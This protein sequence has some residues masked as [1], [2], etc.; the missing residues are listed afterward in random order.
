[1]NLSQPQPQAGASPRRRRASNKGHLVVIGG[2]EDHDGECVILSRFVE[3]CGGASA[4]IAV[5]TCASEFPQESGRQYARV[6]QRLGVESVEL[7]GIHTRGEA[8]AADATQPIKHCTGVFFTGGC[9]LRI[10]TILGGTPVEKLLKER[11][12]KGLVVGGTSAGAA[13]MSDMMIARGDSQTHPSVGIVELG[14]GLGFINDAVIDQHFAQRGRLGRLLSAVAQHPRHVGIGI[15]EDTALIVQNRV[16]E[17]IGRGSVTI[18]DMHDSSFSDLA[19]QTS[20]TDCLALWNIRLHVLP[21]KYGFDLKKRK[22]LRPS[23]MQAPLT[24]E[25]SSSAPDAT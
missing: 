1:M 10:C 18:V 6:F 2:A 20:R 21:A 9:Q 16:A 19:Q 15:D 3:L 13:M 7:V 17:V 4:R 22:V 8:A 23:A 11:H 25:P 5:L 14:Y 24:A 12:R